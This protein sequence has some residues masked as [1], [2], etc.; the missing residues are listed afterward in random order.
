MVLHVNLPEAAETNVNY[1]C[2]SA[3]PKCRVVF[4]LSM[5]SPGVMFLGTLTAHTWV[6]ALLLPLPSIS[7]LWCYPIRKAN[8]SLAPSDIWR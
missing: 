1:L 8:V 7:E 4:P 6:H 2:L 5:R 3:F